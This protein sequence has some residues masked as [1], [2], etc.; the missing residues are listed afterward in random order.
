[1]RISSAA[2]LLRTA[3]SSLGRD[4][5]GGPGDEEGRISG[6]IPGR[7]RAFGLTLRKGEDMARETTYAGILGEL[8]RLNASLAANASD[9]GHLE[10]ARARLDKLVTQAQEVAQRQSALTASKQETT[11]ELVTL[12]VAA[13]RVA[14]GIQKLLTEHYGPRSEK[15]AEFNL[16]PFRGRRRQQK[17]ATPT[18]APTAP[19]PTAPDHPK[20]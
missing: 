16:Q 7:L 1:M 12:L 13:Q 10:G 6:S 4:Q 2:V 17:P 3:H 11:K 9:L 15:L 14:T 18:P 19:E 5:A 8:V 20:V